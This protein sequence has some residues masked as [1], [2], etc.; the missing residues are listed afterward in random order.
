M[1]ESFE[2]KIL[3]L[4][5][6]VSL[7]VLFDAQCEPCDW[8]S[9]RSKR[10]TVFWQTVTFD[11]WSELSCI[12]MQ[13]HR[14]MKKSNDCELRVFLA[15]T[16]KL[17]YA[18]LYFR[19]QNELRLFYILLS[20]CVTSPQSQRYRTANKTIYGAWWLIVQQSQ[21]RCLSPRCCHTCVDFFTPKSE[22][23]KK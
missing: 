16:I 22:D 13:S 18:F 5:W 1:N 17:S 9:K 12:F 4:L 19:Y 6:K 7:P 2:L 20:N 8:G 11:E 15:F 10:V 3:F 14:K 21:P 23:W